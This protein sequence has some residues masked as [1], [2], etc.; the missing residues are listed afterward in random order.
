MQYVH[1]I[2]VI[3]GSGPSL[4]DQIIIAK[5][6]V[7]VAADSTPGEANVTAVAF[8]ESIPTPYNVI[9]TGPEDTTHWVADKTAAGF[10]LHVSPRLAANQIAGG[11]YD[12]TVIA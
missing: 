1:N 5:L 8:S 3:G 10:N 4:S 7:T 6:Q 12:V 9:V 11:A 2:G